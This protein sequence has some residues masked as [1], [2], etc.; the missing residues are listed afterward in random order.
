[1]HLR[2]LGMYQT[3]DICTGGKPSFQ[4]IETVKFTNYLA[5]IFLS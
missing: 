4:E 3:H 2:L 1:M 5:T